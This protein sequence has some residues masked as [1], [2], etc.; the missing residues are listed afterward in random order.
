M[1][2]LDPPR[3]LPG[4][5][6]DILRTLDAFGLHWDGEVVYQSQ[7][8]DAYQHALERLERENLVYPCACSRRDIRGQAGPKG[9]RGVYP[10]TCRK[11]PP[12][13]RDGRSVR[14]RVLDQ[15]IRFTD[16]LQG[17]IQEW[18]PTESGDFVVR[19]ADG[20]FAYQ[21]AVV[22][23]DAEQGITD[24]VRGSD[25]LDST[26]RQLFLSQSLQYQPPRYLHLPIAVNE[27]GEKLSKQSHAPAVSGQQ[28]VP[29]L[30]AALRFLSQDV[31]ADL[32]KGELTDFW[33]WATHN[34]QPERIENVRRIEEIRY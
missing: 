19:R 18:L 24:I 15:E 7:R 14:L 17:E 9:G 10:G 5:A 31:P 12:P 23:D 4:A 8:Q 1:E 33:A 25:L 6:D 28:T 2:D 32:E 16:R 22:V 29:L 21:L 3:E 11:G 34:W 13:G 30:T 20:L 27:K 26:C